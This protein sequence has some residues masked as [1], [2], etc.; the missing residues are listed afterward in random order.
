MQSGSG[1]SKSVW[2]TTNPTIPAVHDLPEGADVCIV[3]A[4]IAGLSCAYMLLREGKKVVV[5]DDGPIAGGETCRTTAHLASIID[6]RFSEIERLHGEEGSRIAYEGNAA[7][8][9]A[10]E[11]IARDEQIDCEFRRLDAYLFQGRD[12]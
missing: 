8:I 9:D 5:V 4:G 2:L 3:G 11:R 12:T 10:I 1:Q 7:A 6:D